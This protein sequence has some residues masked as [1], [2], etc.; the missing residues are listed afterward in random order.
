MRAAVLLVL[1]AARADELSRLGHDDFALPAWIHSQMADCACALAPS[2]ARPTC[3]ERGAAVDWRSATNVTFCVAKSYLLERMPAFD[4]QFLPAS[5]P[6][7]G[8]SMLDDNVAFALMARARWRYAAALPARLYLAYVLPYASYHEAR[9]NWRPLL[10][11]KH[12]DAVSASAAAAAPNASTA[13]AV[14]ALVAPNVFLNWSGNAWP[15]SARGA[16]GAAGWALEWASSTAPPVVA[17]LDFVACGG[18]DG[19]RWRRADEADPR[20]RSPSQ[21]TATARARR[22]RRS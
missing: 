11:A 17:P 19:S 16:A 10:Y 1:A 20:S 9:A 7:N 15:G 18:R 21:G 4:L 3:A 13:D 22:G 12:R 6:V 5:V 14:A 2:A 8:T